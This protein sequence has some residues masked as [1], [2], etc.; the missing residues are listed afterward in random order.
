MGTYILVTF[1]GDGS[2]QSLVHDSTTILHHAKLVFDSSDFQALLTSYIS[3]FKD[4][5][6]LT[7]PGLLFLQLNSTVMPVN[8][9][10]R[11][12]LIR[13]GK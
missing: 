10:E 6:V 7:E 5:N 3:Y 4:V 1:T 8:N 13:G 12:E 9:I 11:M 2:T